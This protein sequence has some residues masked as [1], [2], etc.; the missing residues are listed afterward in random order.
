MK[1]SKTLFIFLF[2]GILS[3]IAIVNFYFMQKN[4]TQKYKEFLININNLENSYADIIN[5]VLKNS[6]Y[7]YINQDDIALANK[8]IKINYKNL[9][10]SKILLED[11]YSDIKDNINYLNG[12]IDK[13]LQNIELFLRVNASIKNSLLFLSRHIEDSKILQKNDQDELLKARII[14]KRFNDTKRLQ[15][16]AYLNDKDYLLYTNSTDKDVINYIKAFNL[17][18]TFLIKNYPIFINITKKIIQNKAIHQRIHII[19]KEFTEVSLHDFKALDKFATILFTL[20]FFS[21]LTIIILLIKYQKEN[22]K[23]Q[24]SYTYD[25]L[26]NLYNRRKFELDIENNNKFDKPFLIIINI[27]DFRYINDIYGN[28]TG[29]ILLKDFSKF[30]GEKIKIF[31][32]KSIVYRLGGDE[33]GII[34]EN[35]IKDRVVDITNK[36]EQIITSNNF[37]IN[38]VNIDLNVNI[39]INNVKPILENADLA[40]KQ[41]KRSSISNICVF[42]EKQHLKQNVQ[43]NMQMVKTIKDALAE[44]RIIP[45]FQPIVNLQTSKIE[46]YEALVRLRLKNGEILPPF[47][48]LEIAQKSSQ[49][50]NITKVMIEKTIQTARKYPQYRFSINFSMQDILDKK[51]TTTLFELLDENKDTD[52]KIDIELLESEQLDDMQIVKLFI[53]KVHTYGSYILVD[54]FGTGYSNF[55][56]FS[57]LAIDIV[58]IDGSIVKEIVTSKR[59]FHML[60]SIKEFANGMDMKTVSEFVESRDIALKL[61][62]IGATYAQGYYFSQPLEQPL[63]D[64]NVTI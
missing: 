42:D 45:F 33:F 49:Y 7:V 17:H 10:N 20:F 13:D 32:E 28:D 47:K 58:K 61:K 1:V 55:S 22:M 12:C 24:Y 9:Q 62:S 46:K 6:V 57:E 60:K 4:F 48:F 30:I 36:L 26:T 11:S 35:I 18:S 64:A 2:I 59:K 38:S 23:L 19:K 31:N 3:S 51:I 21:F 15:D 37:T 39:S 50:H 8:T 54:D 40:L 34:F 56:Y 25:Q 52:A 63:D 5:L 53:D 29:N 16:L 14:L 43:E 44:D 27:N 41:A